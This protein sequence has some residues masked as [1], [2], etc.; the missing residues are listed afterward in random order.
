[1]GII[2]TRSQRGLMSEQEFASYVARFN[3]DGTFKEYKETYNVYF[4]CRYCTYPWQMPLAPYLQALPNL[5]LNPIQCVNPEILQE[6]GALCRSYNVN[7]KWVE[8]DA[9][10]LTYNDT[11]KMYVNQYRYK[12][13]EELQANLKTLYPYITDWDTRIPLTSMPNYTYPVGGESGTFNPNEMLYCPPGHENHNDPF[14]DQELLGTQ[15]RDPA[16]VGL[17]TPNDDFPNE[18]SGDKDVIIRTKGP[19]I[20]PIPKDAV[21]CERFLDKK[22]VTG[23]IFKGTDL[24]GVYQTLIKGDTMPGGVHGWGKWAYR[25]NHGFYRCIMKLVFQLDTEK[26]DAIFEET[27]G[28][29]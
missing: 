23:D 29:A 16:K 19:K 10:P 26:P 13:F 15:I 4:K 20:Y 28:S 18:L 6:T 9:R 11:N 2:I 17:T 21:D 3:P 1:M 8:I 7:A 12:F 25:Q 22:H 24:D 5:E 27:G 14:H